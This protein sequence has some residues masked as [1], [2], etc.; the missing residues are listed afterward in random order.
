ML[1]LSEFDLFVCC[2]FFQFLRHKSGVSRNWHH[3]GRLHLRHSFLLPDEG[4]LLFSGCSAFVAFPHVKRSFL[5]SKVDFTKCQGLFC[6]LGIV[7][8]VTGLISAIVLSF[9]YVSYGSCWSSVFIPVNMAPSLFF[10]FFIVA[11]SLASH[12]LRSFGNHR[13]HFGE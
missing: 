8:F 2:C 13:F 3:S 5:S 10:C 9:K 11:G 6:I 7:V 1:R 4:G 12:A